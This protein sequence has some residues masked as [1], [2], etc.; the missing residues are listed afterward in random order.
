MRKFLQKSS[1]RLQD[2]CLPVTITA[3][4]FCRRHFIY[5]LIK[6]TMPYPV[7][8]VLMICENKSYKSLAV[9]YPSETASLIVPTLCPSPIK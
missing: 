4:S 6:S 5:L 9:W 7:S 8:I 3:P 2:F 1:V